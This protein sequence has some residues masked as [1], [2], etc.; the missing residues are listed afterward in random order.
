M[1]TNNLRVPISIKLFNSLYMSRNL[2]IQ[3]DVLPDSS[4]VAQ[5]NLS[6]AGKYVFVGGQIQATGTCVFQ[7][8]LSRPSW[9][10]SSITVL[11]IF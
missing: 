8:I 11:Y 4:F 1:V 9:L 3:V 6:C 7:Q 5:V 2:S 10:F